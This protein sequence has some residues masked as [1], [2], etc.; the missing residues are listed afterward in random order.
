MLNSKVTVAKLRTRP[1][2]DA[3][4]RFTVAEYLALAE[5]GLLS[6]R[7]ELIEGDIFDMSAHS[8][9]HRQIVRRVRRK[10]EA[11]LNERALVFG[12]STLAF[13]GWSPEPDV[14]AL[15]PDESEYN[16][17]QPTTG[18]IFVLIEVADT[19]LA[20]DK[21][22]KLRSYARQGVSDYWVVNLKADAT[23]VYRDPHGDEYA[24]K[25]TYRFGEA[26]APLAFPDELH[27]WLEL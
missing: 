26:F 4:H 3:R 8:P 23:E 6:E 24:S 25:V 14:M 18:E 16:D 15:A 27:V 20:K 7:S 22:I 9:R 1:N 12:Q 13:E 5:L 21:G 2:K 10:L 11:V 19:T 17:R